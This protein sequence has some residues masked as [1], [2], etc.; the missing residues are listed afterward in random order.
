MFPC[1]RGGEQGAVETPDVRSSLVEFCMEPLIPSWRARGFGFH[2]GEEDFTHAVWA[3]NIF[4]FSSRESDIRLMTQELT[5]ALGTDDL[6]WKR[7]SLQCMAAGGKPLDPPLTV[8]QH[9][10]QLAYES[11]GSLPV[12]GTCIDTRGATTTNMEHRLS[13]GAGLFYKHRQL[14]VSKATMKDKLHAWRRAP[15][16]AAAFGASTWHLNQSVLRRVRSWELDHI[17]R[18]LKLKRRPTGGH[19]MYMQ[20][21]AAQIHRWFDKSSVEPLY[22]RV[23]K[24]VFKAAWLDHS[25]DNSQLAK[26]RCFCDTLKWETLRSMSSGAQRRQAGLAHGSRGATRSH[27]DALFCVAFA[28]HWQSILSTCDT[29]K[30]WMRLFG[31]F[32]EALCAAWYLPQQTAPDSPHPVWR[33]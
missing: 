18:I 29:L 11:V 16:T 12:L 4:F 17:R 9:G 13:A 14:F 20:R 7:S 25:R 21:S 26:A 19:A 3:D 2:L 10:C 15:S 1:T 23:M 32:A 27:W 28:L 33:E 22:I 5:D 6:H 8:H 30:D 24:A 31:K